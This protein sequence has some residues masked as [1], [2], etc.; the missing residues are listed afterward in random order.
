MF[1][2]KIVCFLNVLFATIVITCWVLARVWIC[3]WTTCAPETDWARRMYCSWPV[4]SCT[5]S[6]ITQGGDNVRLRAKVIPTQRSQPFS[7]SRQQQ[8]E[9]FTFLLW[10]LILK[11]MYVWRLPSNSEGWIIQYKDHVC[12]VARCQSPLVKHAANTD[13]FS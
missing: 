7:Y 5:Y 6:Q 1:G 12:A 8:Q 4:F 10:M 9:W 11:K 13:Y 2:Y 3:P